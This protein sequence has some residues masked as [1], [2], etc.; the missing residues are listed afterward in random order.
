MVKHAPLL[1]LLA[2]GVLSCGAPKA[3]LPPAEESRSAPSASASA[4]LPHP[5]SSAPVAPSASAAVIPTLSSKWYVVAG[6]G[7]GRPW[8][9]HDAMGVAVNLGAHEYQIRGGSLVEVALTNAVNPLDTPWFCACAQGPW[10]EQAWAVQAFAGP[11]NV[12]PSVAYHY[13]KQGWARVRSFDEVN[14][15]YYAGVAIGPKGR[16]LTVIDSEYSHTPPL[17]VLL[18]GPKGTK[19]PKL[20]LPEDA[21][22]LALTGL[23]AGDIFLAWEP[24]SDE[25][26]SHYYLDHW[27][28][29]AEKAERSELPIPIPRGPASNKQ[30][31]LLVRSL[32][33]AYLAGGDDYSIIARFDG[34]RWENLGLPSEDGM[35]SYDVSPEGDIWVVEG[36]PYAVGTQHG[37]SLR[38][39]WKLPAGS[40][41][42]HKVELGSVFYTGSARARPYDVLALAGGEVYVLADLFFEGERTTVALLRERP[43]KD[44][45]LEF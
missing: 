43:P 34:K 13:T 33:E 25:G 41:I 30:R 12:T 42:W 16:V 21:F 36:G 1:A 31:A 10:P 6:G 18:A 17:F 11:D 15:R 45:P 14:M 9:Y 29:D 3:P 2:F 23:P 24:K 39:L 28:P 4:P 38:T 37:E 32:S 8:I 40:K 19:L 7:G 26:P 22:P 27:A 5:S 35:L 44:R 20:E